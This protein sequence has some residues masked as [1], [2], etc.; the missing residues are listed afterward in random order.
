MYTLSEAGWG[1]CPLPGLYLPVVHCGRELMAI[2]QHNTQA[3]LPAV[4]GEEPMLKCLQGLHQH[5][6]QDM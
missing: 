1:L 4:Q 2:L 3:S 5:H 6:N